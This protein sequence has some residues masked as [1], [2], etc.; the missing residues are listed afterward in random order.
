MEHTKAH[1]LF[2]KN[3]VACLRHVE[4]WGFEGIGFGGIDCEENEIVPT[5]TC[6]DIQ[7]LIDDRRKH[8]EMCEKLGVAVENLETKKQALEM[9]QITLDNQRRNNAKFA[10]ELKAI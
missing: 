9:L 8:Y 7:K 1:R 3:F 4:D 5:R 6:N 10:A 2:R